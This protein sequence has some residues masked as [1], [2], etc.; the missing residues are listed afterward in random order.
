MSK[1]AIASSSSQVVDWSAISERLTLEQMKVLLPNA[2]H[3]E[4]AVV[5]IEQIGGL[6]LV[7]ADFKREFERVIVDSSKHP[8][9]FALIESL[10]LANAKIEEKKR[11]S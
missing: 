9:Q 3:L 11:P 4:K 2:L 1:L 6:Y 10:K 7:K 5:T 8:V